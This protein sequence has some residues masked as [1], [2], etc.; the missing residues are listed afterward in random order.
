M[1]G[2]EATRQNVGKSKCLLMCTPSVPTAPSVADVPCHSAVCH[3]SI[4][5]N[6][7]I[8]ALLVFVTYC[9]YCI[10]AYGEVFA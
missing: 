10:I 3:V 5:R 7:L 2:C 4:T 8:R 1:A 9:I 6:P